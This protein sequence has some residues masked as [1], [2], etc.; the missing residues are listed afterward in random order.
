MDRSY[1]PDPAAR[2]AAARRGETNADAASAEQTAASVRAAS[3][4]AFRDTTGT[5]GTARRSVGRIDSDREAG[6]FRVRLFVPPWRRRTTLEVLAAADAERERLAQDLHDGVQQRLTAL[7]IA[8]S[9]AADRFDDE[10]EAR[11]V[12]QAFGDDVDR[13]IDEVRDL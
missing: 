7:R 5:D 3:G 1:E 12:L 10:T 13:V 2:A 9:L 11:W 4:P 8:L 6:R